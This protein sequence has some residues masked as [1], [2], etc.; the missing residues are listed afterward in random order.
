MI[1]F[2]ILLC[3]LVSI[4][5]GTIVLSVNPMYALLSL[6]GTVFGLSILLFNLEFEFLSYILLIVY[7]GAVIILFLFL[8][9]MININSFYKKTI[10]LVDYLY[11]VLFVK[12]LFL[13]QFI[14]CNLNTSF[15]SSISSYC[16][17]WISNI[18]HY[19]I[20]DILLFANL[21]YTH[22]FI[23]T[24]LVSIILLVAMIGSISICLSKIKAN[25]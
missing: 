6:I 20:N 23:Q 14:S 11:A 8:L 9:M 18:I 13:F 4:F 21:L 22:F 12:S 5:A 17:L 16:N 3:S 24:I 19:Q 7:I 15:S 25:N 10:K 1:K 2:Y